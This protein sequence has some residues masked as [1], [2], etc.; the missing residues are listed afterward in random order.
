MKYLNINQSHL[1]AD[2]KYSY[3]RYLHNRFKCRFNKYHQV[4]CEYKERLFTFIFIKYM[5]DDVWIKNWE[6]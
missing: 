4:D 2:R 6:K 1:K 5:N 3:I